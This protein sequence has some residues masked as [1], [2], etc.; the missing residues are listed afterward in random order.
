AKSKVVTCFECGA[1][2]HYQKN[3]PKVNNQNHG[4]KARVFDP[5]GKT[6][7]LGGGDANLGSNTA[8]GTFLLNDHHAYMLFDSGA[9]RSFISNAFSTL[10]EITPSALDVSYAVELAEGRTSETSTV[11]RCYT[12]GLL[13]NPFNI[14]L[15][16][17]DLGSFDVIID[18]DWL[19]KNHAVMIK[20]NKDKSKEKQL[21]DVLTVWDFPEVFP[22]DLPGLP[23]IRQVEFQINLVLGVAPVTEARKEENYRAKD[24]GGMIKKLEP[25]ADRMLCLKNRSWIPCFDKMYQDL[26]K[27]Y[28]WPNMKVEIATYVGLPPIWEIKFRIELVPRAILVAKY[29]Y[30]LAPSEMEELSDLRSGYH[31]LRVHED[32]ILKTAFRTRYGH[33]EFTVMPFGQTNAPAVFTNLMNRVCRPYLDKFVIVFIDDILI[34]SNTREEHEVH[35]SDYDCEVHYHHGKA[36]VV[37]DALGRKERIK[38]NRIRSLNMTLQLSIKSK[39]LAAQ[40]EASD[41]SARLQRGLDEMIE[42]R[43]DGALYY[44]DRIWVSLKGDVRTLIMDEAYKLKYSVHPGAK[45]MY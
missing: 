8:T 19:V 10:L 16:P 13:G 39:I 3:C 20:E 21:K 41:E 18:I 33:F 29:P 34:Y 25:R 1:Q 45:K 27:L 40:E 43:S 42:R 11:L 15:M 22:K 4:N 9:D 32:D 23:P 26:K 24:L 17:I 36:N 37:V 38:P 12:L 31:Q 28:W 30:R 7:V 5:R 6:Y 44:L 35:L 14:D 2:G